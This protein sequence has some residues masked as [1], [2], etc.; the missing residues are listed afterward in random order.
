M[1]VLTLHC[2]T[3][4]Q[5]LRC[6]EAKLGEMRFVFS[7]EWSRINYVFKTASSIKLNTKIKRV[8]SLFFKSFTKITLEIDVIK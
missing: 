2:D 4:R 3:E 8:Q 1:K 7:D 6:I 5:T